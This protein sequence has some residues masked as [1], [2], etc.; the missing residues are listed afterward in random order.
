MV[1]TL[2]IRL[3]REYP[4][5]NERTAKLLF[6]RG[7]RELTMANET[8]Q[9]EENLRSHAIKICP[10]EHN[11]RDFVILKAMRYRYYL[12]NDRDHFLDHFEV[13]RSLL[14]TNT[15]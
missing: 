1:T 3:A 8:A 5:H 14:H 12:A 7:V 15:A 2:E 6:Q 9:S 11:E 10:V 13:G 4:S